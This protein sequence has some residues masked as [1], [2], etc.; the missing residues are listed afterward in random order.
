MATASP[1]RTS[2]PVPTRR[3][4]SGWIT[5]A[6][7]MLCILGVLNFIY[8]IA[9]VGSSNFYARGVTYVISDLKLWGWFLII[10]GAVQFLAAFSVWNQTSWGRWVGVGSAGINSVIQLLALPGAPLLSL[11]LFAMDLLVMYG[12]IVYGGRPAEA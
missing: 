7:T 5:Y 2:A 6:G 9:A 1:A 4:G 12:L 10:V 8:G 3:E 11:A